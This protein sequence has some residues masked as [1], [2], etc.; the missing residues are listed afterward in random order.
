MS[1]TGTE[2]ADNEKETGRIEA[3]SDGVFAIAVTL[4]VLDLKMPPDLSSSAAVIRGLMDE[5]PVYLA[6]V[7]S[8]ATVGV[9]WINHHR[10]L[11]LIRRSDHTFLVLNTLLLFWVTFVPFP[12]SLLAWS[13]A[14]KPEVA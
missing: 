10:L 2:S 7:I 5:A 6:Y 8:F 11:T 12:T 14:Q 1:V 3:F 9:M 13:L 4:L